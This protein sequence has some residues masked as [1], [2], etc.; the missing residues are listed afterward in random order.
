VTFRVVGDSG[1][2]IGPVTLDLPF[3]IRE[4]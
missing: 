3:V 2:R 1:Q 4:T